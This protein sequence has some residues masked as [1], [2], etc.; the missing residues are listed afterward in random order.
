MPVQASRQADADRGEPGML[1]MRALRLRDVV[2]ASEERVLLDSLSG[3]RE[4]PDQADIVR[5]GQKPGES[6]LIVSGF[7][8]RYHLLRNGRRQISAVHI[9]GDFVDLHG[10]LLGHMDHG[11][12]ALGDCTIATIPHQRLRAISADFPHLTRL[13]WLLTLIDA[14]THRRWL[15]AAGALPA[16]GQIAHFLSEMNARLTAIGLASGHRFV[17][18]MS[19]AEIGEA[20]GMSPVHVNRTIQEIRRAGLVAWRGQQVEILDLPQLQALAEFDPTYL[21]LEQVPR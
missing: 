15:F 7:A 12:K 20:M 5:E 4:V 16:A 17:L 18:P 2:D 1:L 10:F 8:A 19:Q 6:C 9:P 14:A 11:V 13:L 21:N 3:V